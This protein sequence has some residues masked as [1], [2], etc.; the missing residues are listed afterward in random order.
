M[1]FDIFSDSANERALGT[2]LSEKPAEEGG[3][4][5]AFF[6][7]GSAQFKGQHVFTLYTLFLI[8]PL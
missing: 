1:P 7:F 6:I 2:H 4:Q 3:L 8:G 5:R